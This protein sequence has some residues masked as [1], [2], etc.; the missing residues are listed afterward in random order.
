MKSFQLIF[1]GNA[2]FLHTL[3]AQTVNDDDNNNRL[4]TFRLHQY[5]ASGCPSFHRATR[6]ERTSKI[7]QIKMEKKEELN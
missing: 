2:L 5:T 3:Q 4:L 6:G 1:G 7:M